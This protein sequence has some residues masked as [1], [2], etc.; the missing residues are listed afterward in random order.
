MINLCVRIIQAKQ[1]K[2]LNVMHHCEDDYMIN[3][4]LNRDRLLIPKIFVIIVAM[5]SKRLP[6]LH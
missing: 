4:V 6:E 2:L 5:D 1:S 3:I